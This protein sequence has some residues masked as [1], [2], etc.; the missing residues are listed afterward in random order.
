M[1]PVLTRPERSPTRLPRRSRIILGVAGAVAAVLLLLEGCA[2]LVSG[3]TFVS[4]VSVGNHTPY[5]VD[6]EVSSSTNAGYVGLGAAPPGGRIDVREVI[7]QGDRWI[8]H[9]TA[10]PY[11]G[12]VVTVTR[13]QLEQ[14]GWRLEVPPGTTE[15]LATAGAVPFAG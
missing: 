15:R 11:D 2:L 8:F 12:G 7:D 5:V 9:F 10:G 14:Q 4:R 6:V 3:P 13:A 1:S